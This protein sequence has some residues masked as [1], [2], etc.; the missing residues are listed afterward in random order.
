MSPKAP[1]PWRSALAQRI[2]ARSRVPRPLTPAFERDGGKSISRRLDFHQ[3]ILHDFFLSLEGNF[4]TLILHPKMS[5]ARSTF[6]SFLLGF[7]SANVRTLYALSTV[8]S[9]PANAAHPA[10]IK[11][12]TALLQGVPW[13]LSYFP[14]SLFWDT[15]CSWWRKTGFLPG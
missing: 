12:L 14:S 8:L 2:Q 11:T 1:M 3:T 7:L 15:S 5:M 13:F 4:N 9:H 10:L 6:P